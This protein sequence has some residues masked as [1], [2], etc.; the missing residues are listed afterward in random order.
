LVGVDENRGSADVGPG[1]G[2]PRDFF[3]R[4]IELGLILQ[5][6][7]NEIRLA[8]DDAALAEAILDDAGIIDDLRPYLLW[9]E[10]KQ[11]GQSTIDRPKARAALGRSSKSLPDDPV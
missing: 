1:A 11:F 2:Q 10:I 9:I 8:V 6:D 3:C 7:R 5:Q 4:S